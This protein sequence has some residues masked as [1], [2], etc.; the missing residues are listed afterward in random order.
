MFM[1]GSKL[2]FYSLPKV[3]SMNFSFLCI[4]QPIRNRHAVKKI[5]QKAEET[6]KI[7]Q[8]STSQ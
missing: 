4:S 1:L 3:S 8:F 5:E 7:T 2:V 6:K